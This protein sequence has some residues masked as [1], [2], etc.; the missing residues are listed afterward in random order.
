MSEGKLLSSGE[1]IVEWSNEINGIRDNNVPVNSQTSF[2]VNN[3]KM[4]AHDGNSFSA[5]TIIVSQDNFL[6]I[7][8]QIQKPVLNQDKN[9]KLIDFNSRI[10]DYKEINNFTLQEEIDNKKR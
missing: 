6:K 5:I 4:N 10:V 2:L 9:Y 3:E 1:K 7:L 8:D